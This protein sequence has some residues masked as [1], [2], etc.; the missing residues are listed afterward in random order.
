MPRRKDKLTKQIE[1]IDKAIKDEEEKKV[2]FSALKEI[3]KEFTAHLMELQHNQDNFHTRLHDV[4]DVVSELQDYVYDDAFKDDLIGACPYCGEE[5]P[6]IFK[7]DV[8]DIE[9][10]NC[11]NII[12]VEMLMANDLKEASND[13]FGKI[14]NFEEF[15]KE[16]SSLKNADSKKDKKNNKKKK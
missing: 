3:I 16:Y 9:C 5:I 4:E 7:D 13:D 6:I 2:V 8:Y 10:P 12:E 11:H 1:I 14:I 15:K